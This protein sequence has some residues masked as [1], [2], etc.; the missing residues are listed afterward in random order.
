MPELVKVLDKE[1]LVT[2]SEARVL[3]LLMET[4]NTV[5]PHEQLRALLWGDNPPATFKVSFRVLITH[6][7]EK[8]YPVDGRVEIKCMP[9]QGYLIRV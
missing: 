7:R 9:T 1:V 8:M 2:A 4:P 3:R 6:L 5:V